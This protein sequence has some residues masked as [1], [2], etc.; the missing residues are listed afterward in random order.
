MTRFADRTVLV[1]GG[2]RGLGR[3]IAEAFAA[4]GARV[5]VGYARRADAGAEVA[6][7]IGGEAVQLDVTDAASVTAAVA[8]V[9]A[10]DVL[11]NA[12]GVLRTAMFAMSEPADWEDPIAVNLAGA[13]RITRAVVRPMLAAKRGAIVHVGSVAGVR[14]A[15]GQVGYAA[16][17]AGLDAM[18][19]NLALELAPSGI[20]INAVVP[21]MCAAG[22]AQRLDRRHAEDRLARVPL[23][24]AG[25]PREIADAVLFLA[26]DAASYIVGQSLVVDGGL[27]L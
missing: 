26:S 21:G 11:V 23:G 6:R 27:T 4:E 1:T 10:I 18:V 5:F 25:A 3:A 2:S 9:G 24:R 7:A 13:L 17:K 20:R 12:A 14:A 16:S 19:K 15:V 22:M 8:R